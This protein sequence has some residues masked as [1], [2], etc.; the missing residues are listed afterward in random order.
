MRILEI[1]S[2]EGRSAVFFLN[3]F[4]RS[5]ITCVDPWD[6]TNLE[7]DLLKLYPSAEAEYLEAEARF[8]RNLAAF[9]PRV[10]KIVAKTA[11]VL[12][13]L[14]V[15]GESFDLI[16]VDGEHKSV[17]AYRD[18]MLAWPL[19]KPDGILIIDDY[20]FDLG[21]PDA[22]RP[23]QGV[24]AF[25]RGIGNQYEELHRAYQLIVRRR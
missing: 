6:V 19:L 7:P 2:Y 14:G 15:R 10:A 25:L 4:R 23:K 5:T 21:L 11:D 22:K 1:G 18:C 8:D 12:P 13:E 20:E 24:D 17:S 9:A 16:Y 3:Y